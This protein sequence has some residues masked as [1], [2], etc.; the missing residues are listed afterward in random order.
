MCLLTEGI[1]LNTNWG[2][3]FAPSRLACSDSYSGQEPFE[4]KETR[5]MG[6]YLQNGTADGERKLPIKAF[7][8]VHSYG[9]LCTSCDGRQ[10]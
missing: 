5:V 9:Q 4:S 10:C 1:D 3:Q 7:I 6:N 2:Y 8:D